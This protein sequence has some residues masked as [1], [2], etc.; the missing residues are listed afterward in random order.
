MKLSK[1]F[2]AV[3]VIVL[4]LLADQALK[5]WIKTHLALGEDIRITDW[6][7]IRFVE[8]KGMAMGIE[9]MGKLFLSI[10]RIL[11]SGAII[12][13][14]VRLVRRDFPTGYIIFVS[15]IFA[16][17]IGNIID[18]IFYSVIFSDSTPY[19]VATLFPPEGGYGTWLHG[20]VVDMF[21]FPLFEFNWPSWMPWIGG[22]EFVFFRYIFN[23]ADASI[24]VGFIV[25]LLFFRKTFS[26]S[27]EK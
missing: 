10:F 24:S 26:A 11:A 21:Y 4:I 7:Y 20:K 19:H 9:V 5:I 22:Q 23:L 16:G 1:G 17:A 3:S 8:N 27:F 6:F 13:Y 25:L 12:Y 18:S 14:L 2:W 15:L